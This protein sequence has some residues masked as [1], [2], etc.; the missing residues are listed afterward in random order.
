MKILRRFFLLLIFLFLILLNPVPAEDKV[1]Q[2]NEVI[3]IFEADQAGAAEEVAKVYPSVKTELSKNL[4]WEVDFMP[5]V[6]LDK[7][8]KT[9]RKNT[10]REIFVAYA[11]PNRNIIVLD[12]SRVYAKPFSLESTL[13]HELCHLLIHRNI[14]NPPMWIDEGVC[15]WA[16]GGIAEFVMEDGKRALHNAAVSGR[17]M[18]IKELVRFPPGDVILAYEES[19]SIVEYIESEFGKPGIL[20]VL[21]YMKEGHSIDYSLQKGL[22]VST[23]ELDEK[24]QS[25]LK[26][27]HGWFSYLSRNLYE[28]MFFIAALATVYGFIRMLKK[29][30][31]LRNEPEDEDMP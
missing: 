29:K 2:T 20:K 8:G 30:K 14:G 28:I 24:W 17:L 31:E 12:I 1:L 9:I 22:S 21:E 4:G 25:H 16:S 3:V 19:K 15:Q 13:K 5:A 11:V 18:T 6:L 26:K 10:G 23:A 27:K 7:G